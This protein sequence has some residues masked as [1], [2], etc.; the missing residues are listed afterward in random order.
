MNFKSFMKGN[1]EKKKKSTGFDALFGDI[2]EIEKTNS[3][4]K[5]SNKSYYSNDNE[6]DLFTDSKNNGF[7]G[8]E[9]VENKGKEDKR[10]LKV[11][12]HIFNFSWWE[13]AIIFIEFILLVYVI[14][15]FF[16]V[17]KI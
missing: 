3:P 12:S 2:E 13:Y 4:S 6:E 11:K 8:I 10:N 7:Y 1:K 9:D 17:F 14:L 5:N 15:L 16:G